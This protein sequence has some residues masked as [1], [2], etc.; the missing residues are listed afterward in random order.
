MKDQGENEPVSTTAKSQ[1]F[2]KNPFHDNAPFSNL[3]S[4]IRKGNVVLITPEPT[5]LN[6]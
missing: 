6:F 4:L 5:F 2:P 3:I 1:V